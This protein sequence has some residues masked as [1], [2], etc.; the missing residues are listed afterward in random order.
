MTAQK[1]LMAGYY[2]PTMFKD[3]RNY[4]RSC[5]SSQLYGKKTFPHTKLHPIFLIGTFEKWGID[6]VGSLPKTKQMNEYLIVAT[7]Y[8]TKWAEAAAV[9]KNTKEIVTDFVYNQ[10]VYRYRCP[11]EIVTNRG[12]HFVNG[13]MSIL[14]QRL[15]VKYKRASLYYPYTN[16]LVKKTNSIITGIIGKIILEKKGRGMNTLEKPF[17][18]T[19]HHTN[20]RQVILLFNLFFVLRLLYQLNM[21]FYLSD[22]LFNMSWVTKDH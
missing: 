3:C 6:L 1:I 16:G 10:I 15:S 12:S 4:C 22:L 11:L 18:H 9:K 19:E 20:Y 2:W 14:L 5:P 8:L 13:L 21:K 7:A 17:G